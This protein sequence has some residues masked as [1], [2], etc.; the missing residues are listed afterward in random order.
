MRIRALTLLW[1][2]LACA[3][4][5]QPCPQTPQVQSQ[6]SQGS[7][8][9]P[10]FQEEVVGTISPE[11]RPVRWTA[12]RRGNHLAWTEKR[13]GDRI[14]KLDGKQ[15][16]GVYNEVRYDVDSAGEA[17]FAF[18]ARRD[19][20]WILVVDGH[21]E[22]QEYSNASTPAFQPK[23]SSL[24]FCACIEKKDCQLIVDRVATGPRFEHVSYPKYS[25]DGKRLAYFG[26]R[27]NKWIAV[28]DGKELELEAK[29]FKKSME[30]TDFESFGFSDDGSRFF[31]VGRVDH[32][33]VWMYFVDGV[34]GPW[35]QVVGTIA[36]SP[37][38][39]HFAY[40]GTLAEEPGFKAF[41]HRKVTG[42]LVVDGQ[43]TETYE[44]HGL[45]GSWVGLVTFGGEVEIVHGLRRLHPDFDGLSD[46]VY[47]SE[48]KLVYAARRQK[49][50]I[51]LLAGTDAGP[52][53][54]DVLSPVAFSAHSQHFAYIARRGDDLVAVRDNISGP[55]VSV[56]KGEP[57]DVAWISFSPDA[58]DLA[59]RKA[60]FGNVTKAHPR[61]LES[62]VINGHES[63]AYDWVGGAHF[64]DHGK[65]L[66]F[67][68]FDSDASRFLRV[69]YSLE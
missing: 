52:G 3:Q 8:S 69:T 22:P 61:G 57:A 36:F 46:P 13:G 2:L 19:S 54:D 59:Y 56:A 16:G 47:N 35:F 12:L 42:T 53:F 63:R 62:V 67:L 24:A 10:G 21:E 37:D 20:K 15:Q 39:K 27:G 58:L 68:A 26:M 40:G 34:P 48:G 32:T 49:G 65:S 38:G 18:V 55:A 29:L 31:V 9:A 30:L 45:Q 25:V 23:G 11:S 60:V 51:A 28:V 6:T 14:V 50:D 1:F 4:A 17:N 44:G 43:R 5:S 66:V 64:T 7:A 33:V 41:K